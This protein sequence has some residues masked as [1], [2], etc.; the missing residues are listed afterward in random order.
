MPYSASTRPKAPNVAVSTA[1]TPASKYSRVHLADEVGAGEHEV[2][3]AAL[4]RRAAEVVGPEVL[5][6]HP[7]A[8]RA[9]EDEHALARARRG[10]ATYACQGTGG[11]RHSMSGIRHA[12]RRDATSPG[13]GPREANRDAGTAT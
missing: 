12:R 8:E 13:A 7:G 3:V 1:S 5:V 10:T 9:V 2:L 11:V 6:L 4:E